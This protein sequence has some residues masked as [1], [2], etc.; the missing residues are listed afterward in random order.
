M[1]GGL[2]DLTAFLITSRLINTL[3]N[4]NVEVEVEVVMEGN[5]RNV[6]VE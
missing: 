6:V 4:T 2:I 3:N 5:N 1:L